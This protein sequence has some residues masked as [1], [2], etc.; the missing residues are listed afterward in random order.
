VEPNYGAFG[1]L[2]DTPGYAVVDV[3]TTIRIGR[4]VEGLMRADNVLNRR[5]ESVLGYPAPGRSVTV[6]IR[7]A[8]GR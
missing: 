5:Y 6:G 1:G 7:L 2:F 3:G 4:R 8:T